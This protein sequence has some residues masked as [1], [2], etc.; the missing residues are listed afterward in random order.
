MDSF[1]TVNNLAIDWRSF[2]KKG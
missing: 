2:R 1:K